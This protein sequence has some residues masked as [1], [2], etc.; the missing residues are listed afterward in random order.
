MR[1]PSVR[2]VVSRLR[3]PIL[4]FGYLVP[5]YELNGVGAA[6]TGIF[7]LGQTTPFVTEVGTDDDRSAPQRHR[8]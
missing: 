8:A 6:D 2:L 5:G 4:V 3:P 7:A 1:E